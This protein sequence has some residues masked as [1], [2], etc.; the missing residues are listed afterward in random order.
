MQCVLALEGTILLELKLSLN[1]LAVLCRSVI[2]ALAFRT[3]QSDDFYRAFLLA[4]HIFLLF[5]SLLEPPCGIEPQTSAL[6][7]LRSTG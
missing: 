3:L 4:T 6:P 5:K 7:W 2:L 1:V